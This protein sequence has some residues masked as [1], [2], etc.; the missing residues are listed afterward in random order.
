VPIAF[1]RRLDDDG[2]VGR[3]VRSPRYS[4]HD[5]PAPRPGEAQFPQTGRQ[6]SDGSRATIPRLPEA[7]LIA[8]VLAA[9]RPAS[10]T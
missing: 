2:S 8:T 7:A 10:A 6:F 1:G 9:A 5:P 3:L 4:S